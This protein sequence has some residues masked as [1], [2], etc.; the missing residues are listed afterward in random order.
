MQ[1]WHL[2]HTVEKEEGRANEEEEGGGG[3]TGS[4]ARAAAT[5]ATE[6]VAQLSQPKLL[7]MN[8]LCS[9]R[10]AAAR[11][12]S[13]NGSGVFPCGGL[14]TIENTREKDETMVLV[15]DEEV[16]A[17]EEQDEFSG[18]WRCCTRRDSLGAS[19]ERST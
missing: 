14:Q 1:P 10:V 4:G 19:A 16:A 5:Q 9:I 17:D 6:G 2:H 18:V 13:G 11:E 15:G 7:R 3:S 12:L 8:W